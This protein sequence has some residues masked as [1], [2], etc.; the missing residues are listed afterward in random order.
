M[1]RKRKTVDNLPKRV[2]I[3]NGAYRYKD[4]SNKWHTIGRVEK[5]TKK[6]PVVKLWEVHRWVEDNFSSTLKSTNNFS[7]LFREYEK[8]YLANMKHATRKDYIRRLRPLKLVL[9]KMRPDDLTQKDVYAYMHKRIQQVSEAEANHELTVLSSAITQAVS[10]GLIEKN[11]CRGMRRYK[12][13]YVPREVT[14]EQFMAVYQEQN[15]MVQAAMW[16]YLLTGR[17]RDE[18]LKVKMSDI[19]DEGIHFN[20]DKKARNTIKTILW[21]KELH[22]AVS[23][24]IE[25]HPKNKQI[26]TLICTQQGKQYTGRG[27]YSIYKRGVDRAVKK[28]LITEKERFALHDLRRMSSMKSSSLLEA[29]DRLDHSKVSTTGKSYWHNRSK[30]KPLF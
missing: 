27:F 15:P 7:F 5:A 18:L 14:D 25:N 20:V 8:N 16:L 30:S 22:K 23:F 28:G 1:G 9:G 19:D 4:A 12:S 24:A 21:S 3:Q 2:Y 6:Y 26:E 29:S 11:V 10:Y 13:T 17:R